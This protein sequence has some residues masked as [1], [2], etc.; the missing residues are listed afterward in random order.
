MKNLSNS[1]KRML[2]ARR[3]NAGRVKLKTLTRFASM[4]KFY[5]I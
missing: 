3:I 4:T 2:V 5:N 1:S